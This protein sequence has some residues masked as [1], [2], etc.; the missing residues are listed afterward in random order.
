MWLW[1]WKNLW[2]KPYFVDERC[3]VKSR[4]F[5]VELWTHVGVSQ[6]RYRLMRRIISGLTVADLVLV[7]PAMNIL[8]SISSSLRFFTVLIC[9]F[10]DRNR[11]YDHGP[12]Q[13]VL[14][15]TYSDFKNHR[16]VWAASYVS[17]QSGHWITTI[18]NPAVFI[19]FSVPV[20]RKKK[21]PRY[22]LNTTKTC[23]CPHW[24]DYLCSN[25]YVRIIY[26]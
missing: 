22:V 15:R 9:F 2:A 6:Y 24:C 18:S 12:F 16:S 7:L 1:E 10:S 13:Q 19:L 21:N 14:P 11:Q 25:K 3:W 23:L 8:S 5:P 4:D 17:T 26:K 20:K